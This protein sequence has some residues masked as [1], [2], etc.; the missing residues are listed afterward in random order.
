MNPSSSF[1]A[2]GSFFFFGGFFIKYA[3]ADITGPP[4][5]L[6]RASLANL[7][8]S[9][10]IPAAF[11]L[12]STSSLTSILYGVFAHS[13]PSIPRNITDLAVENL[14]LVHHPLRRDDRQIGDL[15]Q[16]AACSV[17]EIRS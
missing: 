2:S 5:P 10:T 8:A 9:I 15:N 13:L 4:M 3:Q 6:S 14:G 11:A 1:L 12:S 16:H 7:I 17:L